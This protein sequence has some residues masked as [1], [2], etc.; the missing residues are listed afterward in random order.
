L[1]YDR[2]DHNWNSLPDTLKYKIDSD[3]NTLDVIRDSSG[4]ALIL[5]YDTIFFDQRITSV[6]GYNPD[7]NNIDLYDLYI[8]YDYDNFGNLT[9]VERVGTLPS[10]TRI[11]KYKYTPGDARTGHNLIAYTDPNGNIVEYSYYETG[12]SLSFGDIDSSFSIRPYEFV[13]E[14]REPSTNDHSSPIIKFT[15]DLLGNKRTVTDPRLNVAPTVYTLNS[16]GAAVKIE[17]PLGKVTLREWATPDNP[18]DPTIVPGTRFRPGVDVVLVSETDAL[19]R[20]ISYRYDAQGNVIEEK[21]DFSAMAGYTPVLNKQGQPVD[22]IITRYTYDPIFNK[23]TSKTDAE[24]NTT[25]FVIDSPAFALPDGVELPT[26]VPLPTGRTG[27]L[28]AVVDAEGN[29]VQYQYAE[30]GRVY[31]GVYGAGDL[32]SVTDPR[33]RVTKYLRYDQYGNPIVI[34]DA[35]G[36]Q[37]TR[38]FDDRSRLKSITDTSG[39]KVEYDYDSLDRQIEKRQIDTLY[40]LTSQIE[41]YEYLP[42]GQLRQVIDGLGQVTEYAYDAL[43]RRIR[44]TEL[45]ILQ[46]D[47][48]KQN[49]TIE[50]HYDAVGNMVLQTDP[51]GVVRQYTYD[52]LNRLQNIRILGGPSGTGVGINSVIASYGYDLLN[53]RLFEVNLNGDRTDFRYDRLYRIVTTE[54]PFTD[55]QFGTG[56][57]TVDIQYDR[58]GNI[59]RQTD[60][61]GNA[62]TFTYDKIYRLLSTTDADNNSIEYRYDANSNIVQTIRKSNDVVT[63][64][65]T[66]DDGKTIADGLNR[67]TTVQELV[68]LG[69]PSNPNTPTPTVTYTTSYLYD[70]KNNRLVVTNPRGFKTEIL[71]D[72]LNRLYRQVLDFGGLNLTTEY[73]YDANGNVVTIKDPQGYDEQG[74]N[75]ARDVDVTYTYDGLNRRIQA[76]YLLGLTE[77]FVYD[78]NNNL[79]KYVD[80]RGITFT[81]EYDNLNRV[82]EQ[83]VRETI[84]NDGEWLALAKYEYNDP[85]NKVVEID[86]NSNRTEKFFDALGR[87]SKLVDPLGFT[88]TY[89]YDGMNL[90]RQTDKKGHVTE[91]FYDAIN[92]PTRIDEYDNQGVF[93]TRVTT[94][95]E[96]EKNRILNIDRR[97]ITTINQNDSRGRLVELSRQHP[98]LLDRYNT[99]TVVLATHA[100]DGNNNKVRSIDAQG[101]I[102]TYEYDG[103]DRMTRMT[104]GFNSPVAAVTTYTYDRVNN[105]LTVKDAREHGGSFDV[106]YTYDSRYRRIRQ[107]NAEGETTTYTFDGNDN[108]RSITEPLGQGYTTFY[109][110]DELNTLLSVDEQRGGIGGV[111]YYFYDGNR[112]KIAQQDANGNLVTYKYD[113]LN[114]LTDFYQHYVPGTIDT[115]TVRGNNPRGTNFNPGGNQATALHWQYGYDPNNNQVL[116]IDANSQ[117]VESIYDYRDRLRS[118][119]YSN[120]LNPNLDYQMQSL[121]YEYDANNNPITKTEVKRVGGTNITETYNYIYDKL[122]RLQSST[123][124]DNKTIQYQYDKQGNRTQIIDPDGIITRY[125]YDQRNRL[126]AAITEDGT[127][128][129]QYHPDSLLK[130]IIYPNGAIADYSFTNAYDKADRLTRF[131]NHTGTVGNVSG[132][133]SQYEY[134]YDDNSNRIRQVET[135]RDINGGQP[136]VTTYTYDR[137]NRLVEVTYGSKSKVGYT[138]AKNGSRLTET[139]QDLATNATVTQTYTYDRINR[140]RSITNS[141]DAAQS[142]AFDYDANGNRISKTVGTVATT[143][144]SNGNPITV[145][146]ALLINGMIYVSRKGAKPQKTDSLLC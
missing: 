51:R 29:F 57:A 84:T 82:L 113:A 39:R 63:H 40:G 90:R 2:T 145:I 98:D 87:P 7:P 46:A 109:R 115:N 6:T 132:I 100:Y 25:I 36:N 80:K 62:T 140:L 123:N 18:Q 4:R 48:S 33:G 116:T 13:K 79:I 14:V 136:E 24:E 52:A 71:N 119:T 20:K 21:I 27:N 128:V 120:H 47:G 129:Y 74:N 103:A 23:M 22:H 64:I 5:K 124:Y 122:D 142:V 96:D 135:Q 99:N 16:Y 12:D 50:Y 75:T 8:D 68:Y 127:T 144:D 28:L 111:T 130:A 38:V 26:S 3:Y 66:I 102:T 95:Y 89:A 67:P 60:A 118:V 30:R 32:I 70:D 139:T 138:Y 105:L 78:Q 88:V 125:N 106:Q 126:I 65:V 104:E 121:T 55:N 72:G 43:N 112:N 37:V 35:Q 133:L 59:L 9:K 54:L 91:Y 117:R 19:G 31:N 141:S 143:F 10:E 92:R 73:T 97:G 77:T 137:L 42:Q 44:Q 86:A 101:N 45:D 76:A 81:S 114:R 34:E 15:Y 93:Q 94:V 146:L 11:E 134:T 41:Q 17:E 61:N 58:V 83:N 1:Y 85:Q 53:N 69:D 131:V 49:L 108:V 56:K 110:Y 107:T